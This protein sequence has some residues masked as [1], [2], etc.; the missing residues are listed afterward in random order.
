MLDRSPSAGDARARSSR[1]RRKQGVRV[2]KVQAHERRLVA[3]LRRAN[4]SLPDELSP[5]LIE[6]ETRR[7]SRRQPC[8]PPRAPAL[9]GSAATGRGSAAGGAFRPAIR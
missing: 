8:P 6:I 7:H 1:A 2:Y 9:M 4:P 5:E 3:A